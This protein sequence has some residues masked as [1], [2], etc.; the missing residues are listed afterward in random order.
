ML[1]PLI[2]LFEH[3]R[4]GTMADYYEFEEEGGWKKSLEVVIPVILL[5]VVLVLVASYLGFLKGIPIVGGLFGAGNINVLLIG[6]DGTI[7]EILEKQLA[8]DMPINVETLTPEQLAEHRESSFIEKY[9]IL[10]LTE[11]SDGQG[12]SMPYNALQHIK[13]YQSRG[14][15]VIMIGRAAYKVTDEPQTRGWDVLGFVPVDCVSDELSNCDSDSGT[16]QASWTR[17]STPHNT[18]LYVL[19]KSVTGLTQGLNDKLSFETATGNIHYVKVTPKAKQVWSLKTDTEEVPGVV[20]ADNIGSGD[21]VYFAF[22]PKDQVPLFR[23]AIKTVT[24]A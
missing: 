2:T 3:R 6:D 22:H 23:N 19:D 24:G 21:V 20:Y 16:F 10:I 1:G 17:I 13:Y 8:P 15:A 7:Y 4:S 5:I 12:L 18:E 11:G 9:N 14:G